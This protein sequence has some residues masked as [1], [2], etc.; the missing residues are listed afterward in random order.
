MIKP[1]L[2]YFHECEINEIIKAST[3]TATGRSHTAAMFAS[4]LQ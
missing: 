3:N 2:I 4:R 1:V